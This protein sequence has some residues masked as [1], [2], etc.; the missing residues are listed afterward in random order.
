MGGENVFTLGMIPMRR[1]GENSGRNLWEEG[2]IFY[3]SR[4]GNLK[5]LVGGERTGRRD[6]PPLRGGGGKK[7][8]LRGGNPVPTMKKATRKS[9][10]SKKKARG[11]RIQEGKGRGGILT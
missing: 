5:N 2:P 8:L 4:K 10:K 6:N 3:Y 11:K 1:K 9:P 7:L